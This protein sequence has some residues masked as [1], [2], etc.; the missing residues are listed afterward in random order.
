LEAL[1]RQLEHD[2]DLLAQTGQRGAD[3]EWLREHLDMP[4]DWR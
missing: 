3:V 1:L 2:A 4:T